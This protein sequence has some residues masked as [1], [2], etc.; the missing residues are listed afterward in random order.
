MKRIYLDNNATT[1]PDP[2]V[3]SAMRE[4]ETLPSNPSSA[5][6][7]GREA[8]AKLLKARQTIAQFLNVLPQE[9]IFTS[10]GTESLNTVVRG[11]LQKGHILSSNVDHSALYNTLQSLK[12]FDI[13]Y[14]HAGLWGAIQPDQ[15]KSAIRPDTRLIALTA[16]N[17][18]TG[19][20]TDIAAI[21]AM[22]YEHHIPFLVDGVALLGKELFSIPEGVSAMAFSG[23]KLHGPKGIGLTFLR[24]NFKIQPLLTGGD[25]EFS[26]RAG[27]E[28]LAAILG[29]SKAIELLKEELPAATERMAALTHHLIDALS[30]RLE[31]IVVNG[32]GPRIANTV[33]ISFPGLSGEELLIHLDLAGIAVS[34]GS[35][36]SSGAMEPSRIL[37]NM[38][39]PHNLARSAIRFSLSRNTTREEIDHTIATLVSIV[40]QLRKL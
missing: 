2:R 31:N 20:K 26:K 40:Q 21:A 10:G 38:G 12:G 1:A 11:L 18:E 36:C 3:L 29:L 30:S 9:L 23:H 17:N 25:Q 34:H 6:S 24:S 5:H 28:N 22:A 4:H 13:S 39:I 19:V 33:N 37:T 35:A 15:I 16:V 27:T 8:R 32:A 14:L 7:F